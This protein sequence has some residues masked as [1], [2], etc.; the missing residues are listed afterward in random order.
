MATAPRICSTCG[1]EM[2]KASQFTHRCDY[3]EAGTTSSLF[4]PHEI[5]VVTDTEGVEYP[6]KLVRQTRIGQSKGISWFDTLDHVEPESRMRGL[7]M[8]ER[9]DRIVR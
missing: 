6:V 5:V 2:V 9:G 1:N 3:C 7:N 8:I 4:H